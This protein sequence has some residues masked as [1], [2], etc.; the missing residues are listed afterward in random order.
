MG[1]DKRFILG[2]FSGVFLCACAATTFP[3]KYY[4]LK[5]DSY[6]GSLLGP[7]PEDDLP[8]S[9]CAPTAQDK[10][11]CITVRRAEFL[12]IKSEYLDLIE[13]LQ[14]CQRDQ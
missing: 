3:Y 14:A 12:R 7:K 9:V 1:L 13:Q 2:A 10:A 8:L 4:A 5:A 11:P 6:E